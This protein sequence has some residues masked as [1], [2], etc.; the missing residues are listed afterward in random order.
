MYTAFV[1]DCKSALSGLWNSVSDIHAKQERNN[2]TFKEDYAE[3][4][5]ARL[6]QQ[7]KDA[8]KAAKDK[9]NSVCDRADE[10][11]ATLDMIALTD[12]EPDDRNYKRLMELLSGRYTL[13]V[14]QLQHLIDTYIPQSDRVSLNAVRTFAEVRGMRVIAADTASRRSGIASIR[15]GALGLV[16]RIEATSY[17]NQGKEYDVPLMVRDFCVDGDFAA[18][19]GIYDRIGQ[20]YDGTLVPARV[21]PENPLNL[22]FRG[23]RDAEPKAG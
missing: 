9:I 19:T 16:S 13:S 14:E 5:N 6:E 12:I 10:D 2:T 17:K 11:A 22:H 1:S 15:E 4:E 3:S 8:I 21:E 23:V 20:R 7:K 18:A